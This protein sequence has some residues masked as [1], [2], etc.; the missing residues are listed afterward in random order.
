MLLQGRSA[1]PGQSSAPWGHKAKAV[2]QP[3]PP[4]WPHAPELSPVLAPSP[5]WHRAGASRS[6]AT[7][8]LLSAPLGPAQWVTPPHTELSPP[9]CASLH[10]PWDTAQ[11][12]PPHRAGKSVWGCSSWL[13][14][15]LRFIVALRAGGCQPDT[16]SPLHTRAAF[17]LVFFKRRMSFPGWRKCHFSE[18]F[19]LML[20]QTSPGSIAITLERGEGWG[21]DAE[22]GACG[23]RQLGDRDQCWAGLE[24]KVQQWRWPCPLSPAAPGRRAWLQRCMGRAGVPVA[25]S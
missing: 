14:S 20:V 13:G 2:E 3:S 11:H 10:H 5:P 25:P 22:A 21:Q 7:G 15:L 24:E 1:S 6:A 9:A 8:S 17:I 19:H 16:I 18:R 4:T 23:D 12:P